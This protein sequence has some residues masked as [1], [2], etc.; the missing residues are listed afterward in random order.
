MILDEIVLAHKNGQARGITSICSAHPT[1]LEAALVHAAERDAPVLIEATCNQV[2]QFGGYTGMNPAAF[3]RY[4]REIAQASR[5]PFENIVLGG[6]HLGPSVWQDEPSASAMQKAETLVHDYVAAGF[7]KIHLDC[8]MRLADDPDG[9]LGVEVSAR[10]TARLA[11]TTEM[12]G[13]QNL[14]YVIGSEVPSPGG[15]VEQGEGIHVTAVDDA[16]ETIEVTREAFLRQG[17]EGAWHRVIAVVVQPGVE[18]GD[19]VVMP[20]QPAA[21]R[22]LSQFIECQPM[23]YEAHSTDYQTR[24]ALKNLVRDHFAILKVGPALTFAYREAVFALAM[25]EDELFPP[26]ERSN[27]IPVLEAAMLANPKHWLKYYR[28]SEMEQACKRKFSLSD[29]IR[30]YWSEPDVQRA[31]NAMIARL[32]GTSVPPGLMRQFAPE[33]HPT[34]AA[35]GGIIEPRPILQAKVRQVLLDYW[36]ACEGP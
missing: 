6:D 36:Q 5:F 17:L 3:A 2:N 18:F 23:I 24:E 10:R 30:Y 16:R 26:D 28:G 35:S 7:T 31:L 29:R 20:Y 27:V 19:D 22:E 12:F 15:A 32:S 4:L 33:F 8:S 14:R 13:N 1:V 11:V 34:V 25:M 21:A 9:P